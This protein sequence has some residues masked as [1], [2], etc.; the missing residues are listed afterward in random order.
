MFPFCETARAFPIHRARSSSTTSLPLDL[1]ARHLRESA[2][3]A[4]MESNDPEKELRT[5][6]EGEPQENAPSPP[7]EK[8]VDVDR[9]D[10]DNASKSPKFCVLVGLLVLLLTAVVVPTAIHL[11]RKNADA[12]VFTPLYDTSKL[13]LYNAA[14]L[15]G[16]D[17]L[18]SFEEDLTIAAQ[19]LV[20]N[21]VGRSS[22]D[23]RYAG[24]GWGSRG[25][26]PS[27][28]EGEIASAEDASSPEAGAPSFNRA[29]STDAQDDVGDDVDDFGTNN[30]EGDVE[31]GDIIVAS[32][33]AG[34]HILS[35]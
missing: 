22:G 15:E 7:D 20:N 6:E 23:T 33:Q 11:R 1:R 25:S 21:A 9:K 24:G 16:Y 35:E 10:T 29:A 18:E 32:K 19:H 3:Q 27:I 12:V 34:K 8:G 4:N 2:A 31:E 17:T 14:I 28:F 30:Q 13:P 5:A 26:G